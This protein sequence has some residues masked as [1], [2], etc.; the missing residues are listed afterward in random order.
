MLSEKWEPKNHRLREKTPDLLKWPR[1][2]P[3][4]ETMKK[5]MKNTPSTSEYPHEKN[6]SNPIKLVPFKH[7]KIPSETILVASIKSH[8]SRY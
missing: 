5:A 8:H 4:H 3:I 2:T 6:P 7:T 1:R